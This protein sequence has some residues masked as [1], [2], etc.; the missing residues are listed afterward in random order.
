MTCKPP[1]TAIAVCPGA[2]YKNIRYSGKE[3]DAT[4]L[5]DC[6]HRYY[7]PWLQR[8][9]NPDPAGAID[10][11]NRYRAMRHRP[12][13][14]RDSDGRKPEKKLDDRVYHDLAE[15]KLVSPIQA[16]GMQPVRNYFQSNPD[17]KV[18]DYRRQIPVELA[19][20]GAKSGALLNTHEAHVRAVV[21]TETSPPSGPVMYHGGEVLSAGLSTL[22]GEAIVQ[23]GNV[24]DP[25]GKSKRSRLPSPLGERLAECRDLQK[26]P[27]PTHCG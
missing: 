11:H 22:L 1:A 16:A 19:K 2:S 24:I 21:I 13:V 15:Q 7:I 26:S 3:R 18:Q 25:R 14:Y 8:W 27:R 5:Y 9:L 23:G 20:L 10:G 4:G 12:V 17:P 6:G